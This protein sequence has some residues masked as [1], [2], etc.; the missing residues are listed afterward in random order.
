M[1]RFEDLARIFWL[2]VEQVRVIMG[3]SKCKAYQVVREFN[4]ELEKKGKI[5]RPA[6]VPAKLFLQKLFLNDE[7]IELILE[8]LRTGVR[9]DASIRNKQEKIISE[10]A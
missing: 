1:R 7:E 6:Y 10:T 5:I 3:C 8:D 4:N 2:D 9:E